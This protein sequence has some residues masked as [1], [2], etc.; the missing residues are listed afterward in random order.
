MRIESDRKLES[1]GRWLT[2]R[3]LTQKRRVGY[4]VS[5]IRRF[6]RAPGDEA[7]RGMAGYAAGLPGGLGR[8]GDREDWQVRQAA[9]AVTLY[10]GQFCVPADTPTCS[11]AHTD[12]GYPEQ[13]EALAEMRR[14]MRLRHYSPRTESSYLN[15]AR[16][17]LVYT[18]R[19]G[20][21][22]PAAEDVKSYLSHLAIARKVAASTQNQAFNALLFLFRNVFQIQL[23]DMNSVVR[24]RSGR[25]LPVVLSPEET[26]AV[27][28]AAVGIGRVMLELMY[29]GGLRVGELVQLRV[30]DIPV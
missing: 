16:R 21:T 26:R 27:L 19:S 22:R 10:F 30:K 8:G 23:D 2:A 1:F 4:F 24:A 12:E 14:L 17:F 6:L 29:G 9:E 28:E 7:Q 5:W 20:S 15:W 3:R 13:G 25:K 11:T 18:K